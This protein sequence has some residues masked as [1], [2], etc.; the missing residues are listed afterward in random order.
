MSL[1]SYQFTFETFAPMKVVSHHIAMPCCAQLVLWLQV[2]MLPK[3]THFHILPIV[4][5]CLYTIS[6]GVQYISL[7]L[8]CLDHIKVQNTSHYEQY[9]YI[10]NRFYMLCIVSAGKRAQYEQFHKGHVYLYCIKW[11]QASEYNS[12]LT[13]EILHTI[14]GISLV[15][16]LK[17]SVSHKSFRTCCRM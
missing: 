11:H 10:V 2:F 16:Q 12:K 9:V 7:L 4:L 3:R 8:Q 17:A 5:Y 13:P 6:V 14:P 1:S 15:R